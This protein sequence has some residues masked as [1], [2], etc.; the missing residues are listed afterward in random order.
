MGYSSEKHFVHSFVR[1][2]RQERLLYELTT[3]EK[4]YD[5]ISRFCHRAEELLDPAKI[6]LKG[7]DMDR[8]PEFEQF[9]REHDEPCFVLSPDSR[10]DGRYLPTKEA[11][12]Q[13]AL[14]LD[15]V[16]IIGSTFAIAFGEP[17]KS[18]REKYLLSGK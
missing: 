3:P 18:G 4:R 15:A 6:V 12:S 7:K 13:A 17:E 8:R 16:L 11:V 2:G 10:M 14:C 5:G 1:K 9:V